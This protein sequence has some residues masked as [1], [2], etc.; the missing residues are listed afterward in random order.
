MFAINL[1]IELF[2]GGLALLLCKASFHKEH[3]L[4]ALILLFLVSGFQAPISP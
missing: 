4:R 2:I 1:Y 3:Y